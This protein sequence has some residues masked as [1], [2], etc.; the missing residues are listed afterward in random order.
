MFQELFWEKNCTNSSSNFIITPAHKNIG[1][2]TAPMDAVAIV[3]LIIYRRASK[4]F[5]GDGQDE[6]I[7]YLAW[8]PL[9]IGEFKLFFKCYAP[10]IVVMLLSRSDSIDLSLY[11]GKTIF[12]YILSFWFPLVFLFMTGMLCE[13]S[14]CTRIVGW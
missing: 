5:S 7:R 13:W 14:C 3:A 9:P 10:G 1:M 12:A 4:T 8:A 11:F 2:K 6:S